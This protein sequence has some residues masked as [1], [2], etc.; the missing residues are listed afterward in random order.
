VIDTPNEKTGG[1]TSDGDVRRSNYTGKPEY[2]AAKDKNGNTVYERFRPSDA[3]TLAAR[4]KEGGILERLK[5]G[6][7]EKYGK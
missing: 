3:K 6:K 1:I 2:T 5:R 7:W 4:I